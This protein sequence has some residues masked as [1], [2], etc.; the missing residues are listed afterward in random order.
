MAWRGMAE[1]GMWQARMKTVL[2][3]LTMAESA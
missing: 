2:E 3:W 1:L